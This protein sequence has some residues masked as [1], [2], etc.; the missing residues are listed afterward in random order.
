[1]NLPRPHSW[2]YCRAGFRKLRCVKLLTLAG[3]RKAC[4]K[5]PLICPDRS[6]NVY[7]LAKYFFG[8]ACAAGLAACS[9][10][11]MGLGKADRLVVLP[12]AELP[13]PPGVNPNDQSRPYYLG[14]KDRIA[15][16]VYGEETLSAPSLLV[17]GGGD[18]DLPV[19]GE[20]AALGQTTNQLARQ[21]EGRLRPILHKPQVSVN[22]LDAAS[23]TLL[24]DGAVVKPGIYPVVG[25]LTLMQVIAN[26]GGTQEFAI[27][28]KFVLMRKIEGKTIAAIYNVKDIRQGVVQDPEVFS[29]DVILVGHSTMRRLLRDILQYTPFILIAGR[30]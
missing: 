23:Q 29:G 10:S 5:L 11:T 12:M 30:R 28:E 22:I 20:V 14:P 17:S 24:I 26:A 9:N 4:P 13:L 6:E 16:N 25:R 8:L 1:M 2:L 3:T 19:I 21:I 18:V 27:V 7:M 15:V